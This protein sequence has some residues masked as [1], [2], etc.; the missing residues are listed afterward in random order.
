MYDSDRLTQQVGTTGT[1]AHLACKWCGSSHFKR[2]LF[3]L[4]EGNHL[5]GAI[6]LNIMGNA[7]AAFTVITASIGIPF[8]IAQGGDPIVAGALA[9]TVDSVVHITSCTT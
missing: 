4:P 5:I 1:L 8:V 2:Y 6:A 7:F 9:M 3:I